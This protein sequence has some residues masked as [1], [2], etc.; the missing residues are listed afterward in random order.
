MPPPPTLRY[1]TLMEPDAPS[2]QPLTPAQ[3]KNASWGAIVS[4]VIILAMVSAGA[5][6]AFDSRA[7]KN[8]PV[9]TPAP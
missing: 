9:V 3:K 7:A 1:T 4:I 5:L 2:P 6:Y 8:A